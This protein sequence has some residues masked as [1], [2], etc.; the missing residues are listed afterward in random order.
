MGKSKTAKKKRLKRLN[1]KLER[2]M[3]RPHAFPLEVSVFY[4]YIYIFKPL[5]HKYSLEILKVCSKYIKRSLDT[6]QH[7]MKPNCYKTN[8]FINHIV[9]KGNNGRT[10]DD[11]IEA[12]SKNDLVDVKLTSDA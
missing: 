3:V 9:L 11:E 8:N 5:L 7:G 10:V 12:I 6:S 4:I 1:A 2:H